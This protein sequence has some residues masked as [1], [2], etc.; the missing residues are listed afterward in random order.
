[1]NRL[2]ITWLL[3]G[4]NLLGACSSGP[5][6]KNVYCDPPRFEGFPS[7]GSE[8]IVFMEA[9]LDPNHSSELGLDLLEEGVVPVKLSLQLKGASADE[10]IVQVEPDRWDARLYLLDGTV[11]PWVEV[12]DVVERL[13]DDEAKQ[14]R[15]LAFRPKLVETEPLTGY[16]FFALDPKRT[17]WNGRRI[18]HIEKGSS[19]P[20][21]LEDSLL[22]FNLTQEDR[23]G[24]YFVGIRP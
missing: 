4:A 17:R 6:V 8:G 5:E 10:R 7:S 12:E 19:R 1:M 3:L 2:H 24:V 15:R 16:V 22:A 11:L 9:R 21:R 20:L 14:L 18:D 23:V 13:D